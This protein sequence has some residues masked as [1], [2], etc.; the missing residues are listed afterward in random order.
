MAIGWQSD[1]NQMAIT[2]QSGGNHMVTSPSQFKGHSME[3]DGSSMAITKDR[4][5]RRLLSGNQW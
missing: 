4:L 3:S 5:K 2:W 1:G